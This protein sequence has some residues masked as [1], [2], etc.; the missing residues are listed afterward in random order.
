MIKVS[1]WYRKSVWQVHTTGRMGH[2]TWSCLRILCW[3]LPNVY[4]CFV[5]SQIQKSTAKRSCFGRD[6][7]AHHGRQWA[8]QFYLWH[9]WYTPFA[10]WHSKYLSICLMGT[11]PKKRH[12]NSQYWWRY[13]HLLLLT[14]V[15]SEQDMLHSDKNHW[16]FSH[17]NI[18]DK[19]TYI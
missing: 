5:W 6:M 1:T 19:C 17:S 4:L 14:V 3:D 16:H 9:D 10:F 15:N 7:A 12:T 13:C 11:S 2:S 8:H 18:V